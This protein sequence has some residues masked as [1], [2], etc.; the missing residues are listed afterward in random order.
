[1]SPPCCVPHGAREPQDPAPADVPRATGPARDVALIVPIP[2]GTATL[3]TEPLR[4]VT[5]TE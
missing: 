4:L 2:G 5:T 1:M 3:G